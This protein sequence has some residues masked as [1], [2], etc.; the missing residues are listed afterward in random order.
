MTAIIYNPNGKVYGRGRCENCGELNVF[1]IVLSGIRYQ[2]GVE[3]YVYTCSDCDVENVLSGKTSERC[4]DVLK[5]Q[6][7]KGY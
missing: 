5:S 3:R 2:N 4:K 6:R 1:E 7:L